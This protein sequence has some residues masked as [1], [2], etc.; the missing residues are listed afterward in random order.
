V[1]QDRVFFRDDGHLTRDAVSAAADGQLADAGVVDHLES[2]DQCLTSVGA[3]A[4]GALRVDQLVASLRRERAALPRRRVS[5]AA[6][7]AAG[8]ALAALAFASG[9][10]SAGR[11]A[12]E[13]LVQDGGPLATPLRLR[14]ELD[15]LELR[16][17]EP[18][19]L[20]LRLGDCLARG[21]TQ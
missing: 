14:F 6:A 19:E 1:T 7:V 8:C 13:V 9:R 10:L 15:P 20:P 3:D 12:P 11:A 4:L 5:R 18:V 21:L 2:C 17:R 16:L